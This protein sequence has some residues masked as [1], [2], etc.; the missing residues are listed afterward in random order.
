[1]RMAIEEARIDGL[2][3]PVDHIRARIRLNDFLARA[4]AGDKAIIADSNRPIVDDAAPP[5]HSSR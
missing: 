5:D 4:N 1:M 2:P 3:T